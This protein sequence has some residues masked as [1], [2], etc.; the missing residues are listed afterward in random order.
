MT[1]GNVSSTSL[2]QLLNTQP[3][4]IELINNANTAE[5]FR[6]GTLLELDN[7]RL[8][9]CRGDLSRVYDLWIQ[10][11]AQN[12]TRKKLL[13]ALRVIGQ[14]DVAYRYEEYLKS[15]VSWLHIPCISNYSFK[16]S[17][18]QP[19]QKQLSYTLVYNVSVRYFLCYSVKVIVEQFDFDV[20]TLSLSKTLLVYNL[21]N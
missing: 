19:I 15:L 9:E 13:E 1:E 2:D 12:A 11:K 4:R 20:E 18:H 6:L 10:E 21:I 16:N 3:P 8:N 17:T 5:V 14:N 7:V